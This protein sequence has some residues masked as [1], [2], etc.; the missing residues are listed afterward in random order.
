MI[1]LLHKSYTLSSGRLVGWFA[2]TTFG[3]YSISLLAS[4]YNL[5]TFFL[6]S[7]AKLRSL[8]E[9]VFVYNCICLVTQRTLVITSIASEILLYKHTPTR[10]LVIY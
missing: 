9:V 8:L 3:S 7:A 4:Q 6:W 1:M 10:A 2:M 5:F